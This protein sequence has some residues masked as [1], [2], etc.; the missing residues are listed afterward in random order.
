MS[1]D[2]FDNYLT[3]LASLL[4]LRGQ[5]REAI[6]GEL[7]AHLED[8]LDDLLAQGY[9]RDAAVKLALE[10]FGDAAGL[11]ANFSLSIRN[12][13]RRWIVKMTS[14]STAVLVL[15][16]VGLMAIWPEHRPGPAP[17]AAIGQNPAQ[18]SEQKSE[19]V[20]PK[21]QA[22]LQPALAKPQPGVVIGG[23][24]SLDDKLSKRIAVEFLD[25]P[26]SEVLTFLSD[27]ADVQMFVNQR[28]LE[29]EGLA[30]D[31]PVTISLKS[32][33]VDM[34]LDLVLEQATT[35]SA[36]YVERDG[37]L[38]ISTLANLEGA[39]EVRVYNCRD[40]LAMDAPSKPSEK[41]AAAVAPATV[42]AGGAAAAPAGVFDG[43]NPF[44]GL[45][46]VACQAPL[47]EEA[48]RATALKRLICTAVKPDSWQDSG[49]FGTISDYNGLLV[50]TQNSKTHKQ[51]ENV[52]KMLR[53][54]SGLDATK[55]HKVISKR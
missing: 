50:V 26:L 1:K 12:R 13:R 4:Q 41:P 47:S 21:N 51:I 32:V 25:T 3:L 45:E 44:A 15:L 10:E 8:R 23:D 6:A 27:L 33:R 7:R 31:T 2:E 30:V 35:G 49:G 14:Y 19:N 20:G 55:A 5:Q 52:L 37:I 40:L 43:N 16:A 28:A 22:D 54:A 38:I 36:T 48:Q 18:N 34:L 46:T 24:N 11:A 53:E 29:N 39:S 42:G 9:D 17:R